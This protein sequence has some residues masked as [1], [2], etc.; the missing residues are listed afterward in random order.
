M[1]VAP[2]TV[3]AGEQ[4]TLGVKVLTEPYVAAS[5]CTRTYPNLHS[6]F[7]V[8]PRGIV[9]MDNAAVRWDGSLTI[10]GPDDLSGPRRISVASLPG[11][12]ADDNRAIG[13]IGPFSFA[14]PGTRT[15][16]AGLPDVG[17]D[18]SS[19]VIEVSHA[20]PQWRLFWGDLH[21]QSIF[22]DGI[23][24]PDELYPFARDE[25][26]LDIFA[27]ADHSDALKGA[28]WDYMVQATNLYNDPGRFITLVGFEWTANHI[29]HR[30]VYFP[31]DSGPVLSDRRPEGDTLDKL[32]DFAAR[33]GALLI[34]HHS[35]NSVM[36]V[37]WELGHEPVHERL[38]EIYSIWGNSERPERDGNPRPI[39]VT[40]GE[41]DGRHVL[42]AL[43]MGRQLGF[44]GG[45]DIHDGRPG[46]ELHNLQT[47]PAVYRDLHRQGIM[48]VWMP[49]LT[50]GALWEA[51]WNRRCYA[52]T[53]ARIILRFAVCGA[54]MG[55]R[56]LAHGPRSVHVEAS[57]ELPIARIDI[58]K[59][60]LDW[61]TVAPGTPQAAQTF[62]D[63]ADSS[64]DYYYARVTR[65]DGEMAWSSPVW[66]DSPNA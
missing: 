4:F 39:R 12:F 16:T 41:Q 15:I 61:K 53:N 54:F 37:Q 5:A 33:E 26:F 21:S 14:N 34:P 46:D 31:G 48:G 43:N 9:Y 27:M 51:L 29:G 2:S 13:R 24:C 47:M 8:S 6:P 59:N 18:A 3:A 58:V 22:S 11:G 49:E 28:I 20:G 42:D 35:A 10:D 57:S 36:G 23:R 65:L 25:A 64:S 63:T 56:V 40:G 30:N 38:V 44:V 19:N 66:V 52:T 45:G 7:N 62:T 60:G 55:Q 1:L 17:V 32:F 50:R